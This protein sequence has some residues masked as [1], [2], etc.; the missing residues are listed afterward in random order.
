VSKRCYRRGGMKAGGKAELEGGGAREVS[1]E[2]MGERCM[3]RT[4]GD[5]QVTASNKCSK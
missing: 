4:D 3:E 2:K 1:W 5:V